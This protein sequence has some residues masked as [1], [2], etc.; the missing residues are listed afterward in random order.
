MR[1]TVRR[2]VSLLGPAFIAAIAYVDPGNVA[3]NV[4]AGS[5]YGYLLVWVVGVA[6]F[7]AGLV[8]YLSDKLGLETQASLSTQLGNSLG[9]RARASYWLQAESTAI[10]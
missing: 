9:K 4:T 1:I 6:N 2:P 8:Q 10:R 3:T 5:Q 7:M